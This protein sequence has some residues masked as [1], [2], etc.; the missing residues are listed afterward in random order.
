MNA[1]WIAFPNLPADDIGWRMG[2][3]E[4]HYDRFYRWFSSLTTFQQNAF[5]A[6]NPPPRGWEHLYSM[7]RENP[8]ADGG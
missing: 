7:I 1:P 8:W 2:S 6:E 5:A 3:G 4:D